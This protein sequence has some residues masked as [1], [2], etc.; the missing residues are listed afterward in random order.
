MTA[1]LTFATRPSALARWQ[2]NHVIERLQHAWPGLTCS[3]EIIAT[4]GD[5][6]LDKPL[7]EIGGKGLFTYELEEALRAGRVD[8]AVHSLKDLPTEN[9]PGL[10][11]GAIPLRADLRDAWICPGG[12]TLHT[13]PEGAVVGTSS[14]RRRAQLLAR[15]PDLNVQPIRGN[16]D[17][18]LHKVQAG[19]YD[20]II[21]AV[22]GVTRLGLQAH[23]TFYLSLDDMLPAPG[24]GALAVQCRAADEKTLGFLRAVEDAPTRRAVTA[25]R[26]FLETLG[27]GCSLPVGAHAYP[28]GDTLTLRGVVLSPGGERRIELACEGTDP[29]QVGVSLA[30]EALAQGVAEWFEGVA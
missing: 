10:A 14:T 26:A 4:Q 17:T 7:P 30:Q 23:V 22:A 28:K 16:V 2:T 12:H 8:A 19:H 24:Q 27:G 11:V 1:A 3:T 25:E 5:R 6:V 20:A 21:L 13:L 18:R 15:R 9:A 29:I